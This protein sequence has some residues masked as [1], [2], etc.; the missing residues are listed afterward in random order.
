[1][2]PHTDIRDNVLRSSIRACSIQFAGHAKFLIYGTLNCKSGKRMKRE[3]RMFF[4]TEDEAIKADYRPC[5]HC[6]KDKYQQWI[7]L[8][9]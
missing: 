7:S 4:K 2:I 6:M 5:G 8:K 3:N 9:K 1:M